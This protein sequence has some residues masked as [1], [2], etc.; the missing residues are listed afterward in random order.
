LALLGQR[1]F[2]GDYTGQRIVEFSVATGAEVGQIS[3]VEGRFSALAG[4]ESDAV[5]PY[6]LQIAP[7]A[8]R[9]AADGGI[10]LVVRAGIYDTDGRLLHGNHRTQFLFV[11]GEVEQTAQA[12]AGEAE[13]SFIL[14]PGST[15][16]VEAQVAGLAPVSIARRIVAPT[17][18]VELS[19]TETFSGLVKVDAE[20]YDHTGRLAVED[21]I[22][23]TFS[24]VQGLGAVVGQQIVSASGGRAQTVLQPQGRDGELIV[25]AQVRSV[26][27]SAIFEVSAFAGNAPAE[28]GGLTVSTARV[29]G[30]DQFPPEPPTEIWARNGVDQVEIGWTLSVDDGTLRWF[31]FNGRRTRQ[32]GVYGYRIY[33][34]RDTALY[35]EIGRVGP[36]I[37]RYID[38]KNRAPGTYRYK[39]LAEDLDNWRE[40]VIQLGSAQD[41]QRTVVSGMGLDVDAAGELVYGLFDA[42]LDVDLND[43]FLFADNFGRRLGERPFDPL[44]DLDQ[45]GE[46]GFADFIIFADY[47][48]RQA[49][50]R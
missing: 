26:I 29:G 8:E 39:V 18:R 28:T 6:V 22:G 5:I 13:V 16:V 38:R 50:H 23:V 27:D 12:V 31:E 19:F 46:V 32:W 2:I 42:D 15:V 44:F 40:A 9:L 45:D 47:F 10:E 37:D 41:R 21:T 1:L 30:R 20:L 33:R 35:E 7:V 4:G 14:D 3:G 11:V 49:V 24:V 25:A 36:G 34:S 17:T 48:G 43:F